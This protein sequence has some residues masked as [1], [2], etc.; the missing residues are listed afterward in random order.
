MALLKRINEIKDFSYLQNEVI[1][2]SDSE[3]YIQK[4]KILIFPLE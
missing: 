1:E 4:L 3:R 2:P